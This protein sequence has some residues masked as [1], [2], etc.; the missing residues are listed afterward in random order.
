MSLVVIPNVSEG[1]REATIK[2]LRASIS[3]RGA[4][5]LDTHSDAS[6][7]RSVFTVCGR[8]DRLVAAMEALAITAALAIDLSA[9]QGLH[10]RVGALDVCPFVPLEG[11]SLDE[12]AEAAR[13]TG[14][15]IGDAG[16]PVYLYGAASSDERS[17]PDLRKGGLEGLISRAADGYLPDMGP[18]EI[19]PRVGAVCVGARRPLIAFNVWI[20]GSAEKAREIAA[21]IRASGGGLPGVRSI[22]LEMSEGRAQISMNITEPDRTTM[23][24]ALSA[25]ERSEAA[26]EVEILATEI[27]G[28]P[29]Q[30]YMPSPDAKVARLLLQP[31]HSLESRLPKP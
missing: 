29:P 25:I 14:H 16:I 8:T 3:E 28:L 11:D 24:D 4:E 13:E 22:G 17:L 10:P 15:R 20:K 12:A 27:V 9:H 26:Q 1:R 23:V 5:V 30:R 2:A 19:D 21:A 7:H 31:G 18:R 6:H